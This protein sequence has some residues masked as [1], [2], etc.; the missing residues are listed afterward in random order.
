VPHAI[1]KCLC[2]FD[3]T[4]RPSAGCRSCIAGDVDLPAMHPT[5]ERRW[6]PHNRRP[7]ASKE[8]RG[9]HVRIL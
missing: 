8:A 6:L 3:L 4:L 5:A 9:R 7:R 1:G 2:G